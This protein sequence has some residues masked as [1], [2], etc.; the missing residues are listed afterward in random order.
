[1]SDV[2]EKYPLSLFQ[3]LIKLIKGLTVFLSHLNQLLF[4][5]FGLFIQ[6]LLKVRHLRLTFGSIQK[7]KNRAEMS[8]LV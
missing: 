5:D 4:M 1:M 6:S 3:L 8:M 2:E 7:T